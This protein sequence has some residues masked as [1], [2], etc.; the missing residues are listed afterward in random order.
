VDGQE[1][2]V[3]SPVTLVPVELSGQKVLVAAAGDGSAAT[4]TVVAGEEQEVSG[5]GGRPA[6]E[7]VLDGLAVFATEI[8][9]RMRSTD[10]TRVGVEF[11]CDIAVESGS[12]VAVIGKA[13]AS[14]SIRVSLEWSGQEQ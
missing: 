13:S 3:A 2:G 5:R 14:S 4:L 11:G 1:N 12:L 10:A 7:Q 8:A 9:A 6:L